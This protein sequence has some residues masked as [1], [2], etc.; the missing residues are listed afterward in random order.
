MHRLV[1]ESAFWV[2]AQLNTVPIWT[3]ASF[4]QGNTTFCRTASFSGGA[5][6]LRGCL[7]EASLNFGNSLAASCSTKSCGRSFPI[8]PRSSNDWWIAKCSSSQSPA[9]TRGAQAYPGRCGFRRSPHMDFLEHATKQSYQTVWPQPVC[10]RNSATVDQVHGEGS[11]AL[12]AKRRTQDWIPCIQ[13]A[14]AD[15]CVGA[16]SRC[17][18]LWLTQGRSPLLAPSDGVRRYEYGVLIH[19]TLQGFPPART[20]GLAWTFPVRPNVPCVKSRNNC[21]RLY[22]GQEGILH[23]SISRR[24]FCRVVLELK[25]EWEGGF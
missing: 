10:E 17:W 20:G 9:L 24:F 12:K 14:S 2:S 21:C 7:K 16:P 5:L 18:R 4:R 22:G 6:R 25:N 11:R 19:H 13:P 8:A 3:H 1:W 15:F 23:L